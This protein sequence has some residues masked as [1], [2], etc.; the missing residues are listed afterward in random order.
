MRD[1]DE[2]DDNKDDKCDYESDNDVD[3]EEADPLRL[4]VLD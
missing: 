4:L 1:A 3:E 2:V